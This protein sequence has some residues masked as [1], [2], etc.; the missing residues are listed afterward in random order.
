MPLRANTRIST[1]CSWVNILGGQK[2]AII[3]HVGQLYSDE[4][5]QYYTGANT[6]LAEGDPIWRS[7][8]TRR[9]TTDYCSTL[10]VPGN[11]IS[12]DELPA[13]IG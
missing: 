13:S 11:R 1:A 9:H 2:A 6:C 3:A 12:A 8:L 4:M 5:G 7:A 10:Y